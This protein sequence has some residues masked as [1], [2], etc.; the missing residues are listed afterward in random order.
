MNKNNSYYSL[1][2]PN[3]NIRIG[4]KYFSYL[5]NY[6]N[7]NEYLAIL[8]YNAGLGNINKW[9]ENSNIQSN[10]IDVFIENIPYLET[11]NYIKKILSSYWVYLNIYSM[12]HK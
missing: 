11:K 10:E 5:V 6:Y 4:L 8:A 12:K 3:E 1:I 9:L 7:G 2:N